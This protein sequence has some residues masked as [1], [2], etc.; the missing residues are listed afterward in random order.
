MG[1]PAKISA[2]I[3]NG[4]DR[5]YMG[6]YARACQ[7]L[8]E[9]QTEILARKSITGPQQECQGRSVFKPIE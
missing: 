8:L 5:G 7:A 6:I 3:R 9:C 2:S 4:T 1:A